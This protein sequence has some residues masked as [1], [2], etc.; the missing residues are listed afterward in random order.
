MTPARK[1]VYFF[2]ENMIA[3]GVLEN[4]MNPNIQ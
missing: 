2:E 4:V 1:T 3:L